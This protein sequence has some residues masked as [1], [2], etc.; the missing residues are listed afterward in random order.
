LAD[1]LQGYGDSDAKR[2]RLLKRSLLVAL[3]LAIAAAVFYFSFRNWR[4]NRRFDAF[5]DL[6]RKQDYQSAYR[7]W[8][9]DP[10][11][12]CRDYNLEKF[13]ED[14]GPQSAQADLAKAKVVNTRACDHGVIKSLQFGGD[15]PI[16]VWIDRK[17]RTLS[18]A[19]WND[20]CR[21]PPVQVR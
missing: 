2:G 6:L 7:L 18:F 8:G 1:F 11:Q 19:P 14:W 9:C 20:S 16:Y 5:L 10:A 21:T 17:D 13:L 15:E 4:E 12:P 3:V